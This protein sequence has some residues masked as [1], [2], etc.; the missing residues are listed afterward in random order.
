MI[1]N[2]LPELELVSCA[3]VPDDPAQGCLIDNP[4]PAMF[5]RQSYGCGC[6]E[7]RRPLSPSPR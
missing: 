7:F 1:V 5:D 3:L 4:E 2:A 6:F